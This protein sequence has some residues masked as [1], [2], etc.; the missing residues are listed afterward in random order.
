VLDDGRPRAFDISGKGVLIN[1]IDPGYSISAHLCPLCGGIVFLGRRAA[2][3]FITAKKTRI[4]ALVTHLWVISTCPA[5]SESE[6]SEQ[7]ASGERPL[8]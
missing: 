8:W 6:E 4:I 2:F 7:H 1:D 3:Q 5:T